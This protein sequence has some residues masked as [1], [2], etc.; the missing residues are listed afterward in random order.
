MKVLM[1]EAG[2][3]LNTSHIVNLFRVSP[4]SDQSSF[5]AG[6][7][8]L[9]LGYDGQRYALVAELSTGRFE[10]VEVLPSGELVEQTFWLLLAEMQQDSEP[11]LIHLPDLRRRAFTPGVEED[12]QVILDFSATD[13]E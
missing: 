5:P 6:C 7:D 11:R 9:G 1:T 4:G 10:L 2:K 13:F 12:I 8:L 3:A